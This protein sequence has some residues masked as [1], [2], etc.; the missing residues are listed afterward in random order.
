MDRLASF[1]QEMASFF[2]HGRGESPFKINIMPQEAIHFRHWNRIK[3]ERSPSG[4]TGIVPIDSRK[5]PVGNL[6]HEEIN[7][8]RRWGAEYKPLIVA[9]WTGKVDN[10]Q[11][12]WVYKQSL[13]QGATALSELIQQVIIQS[14]QQPTIEGLQVIRGARIIKFLAEESTAA[15]LERKTRAFRPL[16]KKRQFAVDPIKIVNLDITPYLGTKMLLFRGLA[17]SSKGGGRYK[18]V[19]SFT[20]V[21]FEP[22]STNTNVTFTA[23]DG[24]EYNIQ[25]IK[26]SVNNVK[27]R[28]QC[29]DH[30]FRFATWNFNDKSIYGR[31]PKPY[32]RKT[33]PP[34]IGRPWANP[35]RTPGLCKH[36]LKTIQALLDSGI[37]IR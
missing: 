34:P 27:V 23:S 6:T 22:E 8:V 13:K 24:E 36:I 32:R 30:Y 7:I 1:L 25:P 26:L 37:C 10:N 29:L 20:K 28:C 3:V 21:K 12:D 33:P 31:A 5:P 19:V 11:A 2:I 14:S 35:S 9:L 18:T 4:G 16:T 15:E 17:T